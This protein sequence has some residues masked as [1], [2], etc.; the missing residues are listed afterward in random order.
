MLDDLLV[1]EV[2]IKGLEESTGS[3]KTISYGEEEAFLSALKQLQ[4][5]LR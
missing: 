5:Q 4:E 3:A 2:D 1:K